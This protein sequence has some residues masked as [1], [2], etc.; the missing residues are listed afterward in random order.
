MNISKSGHREAILDNAI[1]EIGVGYGGVV[2]AS[3]IGQNADM[4]TYVVNFGACN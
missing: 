3:N 4:G 1:K 2:A